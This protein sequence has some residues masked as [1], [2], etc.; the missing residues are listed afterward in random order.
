MKEL[1]NLFNLKK[2]EEKEEN[3]GIFEI[4]S[5][6]PGY[7][8]T[9]GNALRRVLLSSIE[10][11]AVTKVEIKGVPHEFS[12]IPGVMEDVINILL[13]L[14]KLRFRMFTSEPQKVTLKAKGRKEVKGEDLNL[15]PQLELVNK[16]QHIATLTSDKASLEMTLWVEK[17]LGY[18]SVER[19][20]K[21]KLKIGEIQIDAI[22]SPVKRVAFS[23]ENMRVGERTDFNKLRLEIE[24][25]G[26]IKPIDALKEALEILSSHFLKL[27]ENLKGEKKVEKVKEKKEIPEKI[28]IEDL[29]ISQ[30]TKNALLKAKITT[31]SS[32][33]KKKEE[34]LLKIEGIGEK[35][36]KEIKKAL[37]K[38]NLNLK[39]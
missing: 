35:G 14:K 32:L 19:R 28:K 20:K 38:H 17:G 11:A 25:D 29:N 13:N 36:I 15:P 1:L 5:L 37:K 18:E 9:I 4:E 8:V 23:V 33:S 6:Y 3:L 31:L 27:L 22:Y 26:T 16:N 24:T 34:D 30:R 10:G 7:G 39:E 21:E 12:T 2:I